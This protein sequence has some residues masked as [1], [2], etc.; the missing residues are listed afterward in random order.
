MRTPFKVKLCVTFTKGN[1]CPSFRQ[2][3]GG[4]RAPL[5]SAVFQLPSAQKEFFLQSGIFCYIPIPFTPMLLA[6]SF[7]HCCVEFLE[8]IWTLAG[9]LYDIY[10]GNFITDSLV[11]FRYEKSPDTGL[12]I[13]ELLLCLWYTVHMQIHVYIHTC[14]LSRSVLLIF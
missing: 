14:L 2:R 1:L 12:C 3:A 7:N 8:G 5:I 10:F 4:Q 6:T 13:S 9:R 11:Y